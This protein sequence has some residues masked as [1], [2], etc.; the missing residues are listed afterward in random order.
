MKLL[1]RKL[2]DTIEMQMR[3]EQCQHFVTRRGDFCDSG[4]DQQSAHSEPVG[5]KR[6][7][8]LRGNNP[9]RVRSA[10]QTAIDGGLF[11]ALRRVALWARVASLARYPSH[12]SGED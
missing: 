4:V 9:L 12:L 5:C 8:K 7:K 11:A 6:D 2:Q 10:A 1:R 3:S